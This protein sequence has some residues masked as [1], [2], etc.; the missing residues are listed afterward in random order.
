M[1]MGT[2]SGALVGI[3]LSGLMVAGCGSSSEIAESETQATS[4]D[5]AAVD[6]AVPD[7]VSQ[8]SSDEE[9][10]TAEEPSG[11]ESSTGEAS[12][13]GPYRVAP[14]GNPVPVMR[15]ISNQGVWRP[16]ATGEWDESQMGQIVE[17]AEA[18]DGWLVFQREVGESVIWAL[19]ESGPQELIVAAENQRLTL[20]GAGENSEGQ[21][22]VFYQKHEVGSPETDRSSLRAYN[23]ATDDVTE[24]L[25]TGEWEAGTRFDHIQKASPTVA[26][27][28]SG[29]L[30][31]NAIV[32]LSQPS[33]KIWDFTD[34]SCEDG[35]PDCVVYRNAAI[36]GDRN[37]GVRSILNENGR[38]ID[39]KGLFEFDPQA[40]TERLIAAFPWDNGLWY[41]EDMFSLDADN[42]VLS[43]SDSPDADGNPLPA[44]VVSVESG[45][46]FTLPEAGFV[47]P[48][49]LP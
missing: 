22:I 44:L 16:S 18:P 38:V 23:L 6:G 31:G 40:G 36:V 11:T 30:D 3:A 37:V 46:A 4:E 45:E 43:L 7:Q 12:D 14:A 21:P 27:W 29:G 42:V 26:H 25:E 49:Y 32:D 15:W 33:Q 20:E 35:E 39:Q 24:I 19:T 2:R 1:T 13:A 34:K 9:T 10:T 28:S 47:R 41:V 17:L 8:G 48:A 5:T